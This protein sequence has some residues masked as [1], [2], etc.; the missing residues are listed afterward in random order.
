MLLSLCL[1]AAAVACSTAPAPP[2]VIDAGH[3]V[4]IRVVKRAPIVDGEPLTATLVDP[5]FVRDRLV[6]PAGATVSGYLEK[7]H[8]KT[9]REQ[10]AAMAGGDLTP[11]IGARVRFDSMTLPH[12]PPAHIVAVTTIDADEPAPSTGEWVK[13]YLWTQLPY[14]RRYAHRGAILTMT[15]VEPV[16]IAEPASAPPLETR[17]VPARLLTTLDTNSAAVGDTVRAALLAPVRGGDGGL[18]AAEGTIVNGTVTAVA[19]GRAFNRGARVTM[20]LDSFAMTQSR[21]DPP[22]RFIWP[23]LAAL[24]LVGA[25]DPS[26]PNASTFWGRSGAGWSG[27]LVIGALVAQVSEPVALGLGAWGLIHST[28]INVLRRGPD[29][30]LPADSIVLLTTAS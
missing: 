25:R 15:F 12:E 14:H 2:V 28:W 1:A 18:I 10:V 11:A 8:A 13:D 5:I 27:F 29:V 3:P 24:A 26:D 7:L 19:R 23:P 30:V 21:G 17:G 16:P 20:R 6:V 4:R 9:T 22:I